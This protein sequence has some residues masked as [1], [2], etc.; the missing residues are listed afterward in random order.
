[1]TIATKK[2]SKRFSV[3]CECLIRSDYKLVPCMSC[4]VQLADTKVDF[5]YGCKRII[6]LTCMDS[7]VKAHHLDGAHI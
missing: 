6:C 2:E 5:C 7:K 1:M 4:K 3:V